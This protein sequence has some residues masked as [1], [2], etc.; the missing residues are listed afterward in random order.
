MEKQ[1]LNWAEK[2][3]QE[4]IVF[5]CNKIPAIYKTRCF[6]ISNRSHIEHVS[7]ALAKSV[8]TWFLCTKPKRKKQN[9]KSVVAKIV[10]KFRLL[11]AKLENKFR[12]YRAE[13]AKRNKITVSENSKQQQ[14]QRLMVLPPLGKQHYYYNNAIIITIIIIVLY[15]LWKCVFCFSFSSP[16]SRAIFALSPE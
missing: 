9:E 6:E 12:W 1:T 14:K 4:N 10:Q 7:V 2:K 8:K 13:N 3:K 5:R 11:Y 15:T 16:S